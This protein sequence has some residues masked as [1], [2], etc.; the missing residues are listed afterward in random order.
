MRP[1]RLLVPALLAPLL[2]QGCR[3]QE[4]PRPV[5]ES[6]KS[7]DVEGV[8]F[9]YPENCVITTEALSSDVQRLF[10]S[11]RAQPGKLILCLDLGVSPYCPVLGLSKALGK[12]SATA[13]AG[14]DTERYGPAPDPTGVFS[15]GLMELGGKGRT[16]QAHFSYCHLDSAEQEQAE[17]IIA[18]LQNRS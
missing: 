17:T 1:N 2:L 6:W 12:S 9:R 3:N 8:T 18:S 5:P 10:V 11:T 7:W 16:R 4:P 14:F 15:E 13:I